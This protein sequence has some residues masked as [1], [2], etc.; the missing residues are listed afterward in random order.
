MKALLT[1]AE[2][3]EWL[4]NHAHLETLT[5]KWSTRGYGNSKFVDAWGTVVGSAS[6]CGYDRRGVALADF[7][8]SVFESELVRLARKTVKPGQGKSDRKNTAFYGLW[9]RD[10]KLSVSLDGA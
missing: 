1:I 3:K 8:R 5:H 10:S 9:L 4:S 7:M 2:Q 6:G